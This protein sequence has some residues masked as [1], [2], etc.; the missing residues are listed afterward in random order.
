MGP[1]N[2]FNYPGNIEAFMRANP[3]APGSSMPNPVQSMM[4]GLDGAAQSAE[5]MMRGA[6]R[7]QLEVMTLMSRRAQ[8]YMELPTR[9]SQCRTPQDVFNEQTRFWQTAFTQ[10]SE[11]TRKIY[12]AWA[13]M[14]TPPSFGAPA[15]PKRERD[16]LSFPEA[17]EQGATPLR[18]GKA[19]R[20]VA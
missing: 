11:S 18:P 14:F 6:A 20:K 19:D 10:Y 2:V 4:Q 7:Y 5:P 17:K 15:S 8:A 1:Q 3:F 12:S 9:L 13:Q 16:Y